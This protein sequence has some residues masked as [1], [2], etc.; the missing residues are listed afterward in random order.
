[1]AKAEKKAAKAAGKISEKG[2]T[3]YNLVA[4]LLH[5]FSAISLT[6]RIYS[7]SACDS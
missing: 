3:R 4:G 2:L 1:M 7:S 6:A 5:L